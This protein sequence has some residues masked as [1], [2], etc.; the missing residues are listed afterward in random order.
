[1]GTEAGEFL[2]VSLEAVSVAGGGGGGVGHDDAG[3]AGER[4]SEEAAFRWEVLAR[5][6]IFPIAGGRGRSSP[7]RFV[8]PGAIDRASSSGCKSDVCGGEGEV[9]SDTPERGSWSPA[10]RDVSRSPVRATGPF[11]PG[12]GDPLSPS[13]QRSA[14]AVSPRP[15]ESNWARGAAATMPDV[16]AVRFSPGGGVMA[17]S[18]GNN[19]YLYRETGAV[20]R[21]LRGVDTQEGGGVRDGGRRGTYRRYGACRGHCTTVRSFDFSKDETILQSCDASGDLLFW[22]VSTAKQVS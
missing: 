6:S 21:G 7:L 2:I 16:S 14:K 5:R 1:M 8:A 11:R 9:M 4:R 13:S 3:G 19:V 15:G 18:S 12:P 22:N 17:V 10:K 20:G